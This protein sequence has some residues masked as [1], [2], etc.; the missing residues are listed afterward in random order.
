MKRVAT[1]GVSSIEFAFSMLVL[2]P[3]LLGTGAIGINMIK[4]LQTIQLARDAGHMYARGLDV[5]QTGNKTIIANLGADLGLS[6][7]SSTSSAVVILSSLTY[8]DKAACSDVGA[9]DGSGNPTSACTN[10]TKWVFTQRIVIGKSSLRTSNFGSPLTSGPTG[11]TVNST[12]GRISEA[13]YVTKAGAVAQF[14]GVNPYAVVD[15]V[16]Q[17][18][19][20]GEV[21]FLAEAAATGFNMPPFVSNSSPY[22]FAFF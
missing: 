18:L 6:T 2:V 16:A 5:S 12:T 7:N 1:R 19:P 21:L 17:G 11:V 20:S 15:G 4:T 13:D 9:V 8:V 10:F 22:S 3:M 14:S